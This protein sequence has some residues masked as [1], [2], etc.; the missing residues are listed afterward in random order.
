MIDDYVLHRISDD[1]YWN[2]NSAFCKNIVNEGLCH[3]KFRIKKRSENSRNWAFVIGIW[4]TKTTKEPPRNT[5]FTKDRS[6]YA[7]VADSAKMVNESG[8]G[9]GNDYGVKCKE[10]D[11]ID[12]YL[13][14]NNL[15]LRYCINDKDYGVACNVDNASY[16]AA[17]NTQ[18]EGDCIEL[19]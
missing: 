6:S 8:G 13:D 16:R 3:W 2:Y 12:M 11:I 9:F 7:F 19:L 1:D 17:V 15:T 4:S 5:Y 18:Y 14:F 10:G